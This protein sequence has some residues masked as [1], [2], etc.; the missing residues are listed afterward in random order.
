[1]RIR[2]WP[3]EME[4][5][6]ERPTVRIP[7]SARGLRNDGAA[8]VPS[9]RPCRRSR[10]PCG[11]ERW[12]RISSITSCAAAAP[13][14]AGTP[15]RALV[16]C[17]PSGRCAPL[18]H[19]QRLRVRYL[20]RRIDPC[21]PAVIMLLTALPPAPPT[22]KTVIR[23]FNSLMWGENIDCHG[24]SVDYDA[25]GFAPAGGRGVGEIQGAE[26]F[27]RTLGSIVR[28]SKIPSVPVRAAAYAAVRHVQMSVLRIDQE[29][30]GTANDAVFA[31]WGSRPKPSGRPIRT[32]RPRIWLASSECR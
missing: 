25:R 13:T 7:I 15:R 6:G 1:V 28:P 11:A 16:T 4:R 9:R 20:R 8:P 31:S 23:G 19:R 29:P 32:G 10:T 17:C 18:R 14:S 24:A 26:R 27:I 12:S 2:F 21:N 22:P 5:L 30:V 3:F